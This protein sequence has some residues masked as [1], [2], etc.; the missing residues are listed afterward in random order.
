MLTDRCATTC[1]LIRLCPLYPLYGI[2]GLVQAL[3]SLDVSAHFLQ[4][5]SSQLVGRSHKTSN[6]CIVQLYYS[7]RV[8][9]FVVCLLS[10][11]FLLLLFARL[12][13]AVPSFLL[14]ACGLVYVFKQVILLI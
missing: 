5:V 8:V 4:T 14:G 2:Q 12:E 10:E 6:N 3:V 1:L 7:S 13:M 11:L 9:L